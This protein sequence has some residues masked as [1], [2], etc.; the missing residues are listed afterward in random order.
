MSMGTSDTARVPADT[1]AC[2]GADALDALL[3]GDGPTLMIPGPCEVEAHVLAV[4]GAQVGAH[5]GP[6][7]A[8]C[9]AEVLR[10]LAGLLDAA[11]VYVLPGSGS[12]AIDATVGTLFAPGA[13]VV[14]PD[15]GYFGRRLAEIARAHSL[16]VRTVSVRPGHPVT[17]PDATALLPGSDGLLTVHVET[18][19][20]VRH[21]VAELAE[22]A[23]AAGA[24]SVVD[25]VASAGGE[26]L[27]VRD[28][29]LDAVVTAPQKGLGAP[30]GLGIVA[31]GERT[32][33]RS[34]RGWYLNLATWDG[35]REESPD[36][37][38]H[39]VTMPTNVVLAL[40]AAARHILRQGGISARIARSRQLADYCRSRLERIGLPSAASPD[41]AANLVVVVRHA[42]AD[43]LRRELLADAG[44]A[45]AGGL[46][47]FDQGMLR[48]G[49]LGRNANEAAVDRLVDALD[50]LLAS[51]APAVL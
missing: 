7:W 45:I 32:E 44:I 13:T 38:P 3:V 34:A 23:R 47:P 33:S 48:I 30:P 16:F 14:V 51:D 6:V 29:G 9:H 28:M 1:S 8:A 43:E 41:A 25:A 35:A 15:T 50:R 21:P 2:V 19:T 36:W 10:L 12:A 37:E 24:L 26:E 31:L 17:V 39:P 20:G 11:S 40:A 5:Y 4:L 27:S 49:L 42:R 22:A 46:A 18:S